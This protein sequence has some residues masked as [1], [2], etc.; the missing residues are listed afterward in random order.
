MLS[1]ERREKQRRVEWRE[2][3]RM[4]GSMNEETRHNGS[5]EGV[6]IDFQCEMERDITMC[7]FVS[8]V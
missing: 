4:E 2:N 7:W 6:S 8:E 5:D 1:I 3:I